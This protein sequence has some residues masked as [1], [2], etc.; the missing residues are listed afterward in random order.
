MRHDGLFW[1]VNPDVKYSV[2]SGVKFILELDKVVPPKVGFKWI[3][4]LNIPP[5]LKFI[6]WKLCVDGLPTKCRLKKLYVFMPKNYVFYN[7]HSEDAFHLF[8]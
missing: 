1:R 4:S 8:V 3:W 7:F 5:K 6:L 2:K